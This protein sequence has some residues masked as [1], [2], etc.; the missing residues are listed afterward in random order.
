MVAAGEGIDKKYYSSKGMYNVHCTWPEKISQV[1]FEKKAAK[2]QYT[3]IVC[4]FTCSWFWP[5][6]KA[7]INQL[8]D[9]IHIVKQSPDTFFQ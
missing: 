8:F 3:K 9:Q 4:C 2:N 6:V 1:C 5:N 7:I